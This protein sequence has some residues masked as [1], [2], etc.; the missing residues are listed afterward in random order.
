[1]RGMI[2]HLRYTVRLLLKSPGFTITAVLVLGLGI[3][4]NTA[5]FSLVYTVVLK[6]PPFPDPGRLVELTMPFQG[7]D[8]MPF[9]YPDY[10]DVRAEQ[11]SFESLAV[12][13]AEDMNLN[14]RGE[15]ER[16]TGAFVSAS[17]F[18]VTRM[19]FV[20]GRPFTEDD[21]KLGGPQVVVLNERFWRTHF[22]ADPA[23]IGRTMTISGRPLE[24]IGVAP[25][26]AFESFSV[27]LYIPMHLARR[28]DFQ[29]R[30][31]H[32]FQC[33]GRLKSAVQLADA[34]A[35]VAAIYRGIA[36]RY[37]NANIGYKTR[38]APLWSNVTT[39]YVPTLWVL[40]AAVVCLFLI[41]NANIVGLLFTRAL[42]RQKEIALR[43]ALGA[44]RSRVVSQLLSE[45][46]VL[47]MFG[48][49]V[50]LLSAVWGIQ[51]IKALSPKDE[52]ARFGEISFNLATLIFFAA[53]T[54]FSTVLL[55]LFPGWVLTRKSLNSA[56]NYER[57]VVF[58]TGRQRR[59]TQSALVVAQIS[60]ACV[61]CI[62]AGLLA[63]SF[64]ITQSI[65]LGFSSSQVLTAQ[66][67]LTDSKYGLG[68]EL[69]RELS[70]EQKAQIVA[71][72]DT[73]LQRIRNLPGIAA[74]ALN[75]I[76]PLMGA[77]RDPF[78]V[79]GLSDSESKP[80]CST[81]NVSSEY[82]TTL[83]I[84]L[85]L[86]R[87]FNADDRSHTERVVIIN[88]AFA[89]RYFPNQSPIGKQINFGGVIA[90]N[91]TVSFTIIGVVGSV[92]QEYPDEP[93]GP[94]FQAYFPYTQTP[95]NLEVLFLRST[96]EPG[97]LIPAIRKLVASIDPNVLVARSMTMDDLIA[98]GFKT[99]RLGM[100]VVGL[101]SGGALFLS[102]IGLYGILAYSVS[103][104]RRE[105]GIRI[106]VGAQALRILVLVMYGGFKIASIG[107]MIGIL[108][109]L[110]VARFMTSML[111]GI[112]GYD[113]TTL[114]GV[115][116]ILA[117]A[118]S[119]ACLF[120]AV[121][122]MRTDPIIVLKE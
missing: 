62:A 77:Q 59:F 75:K 91:K 12:Y 111:Y 97:T 105:L 82:F 38:V 15:T 72:Y 96:A 88:E 3:G 21:D 104:R 65:P 63:R 85:L 112:S 61:L 42:D 9:D 1:M 110:V 118:V 67:L 81:Q 28:V 10:E 102:A 50:G 24:V 76:P 22:N 94:M 18:K 39:F 58:T 14:S 19:S 108:C 54:V 101:F 89:R 119:M 56:L 40:G 41:A 52:F 5:I 79:P 114:V 103:Q 31:Q 66:I 106:A 115:A 116:L 74:A 98:E 34:Q 78:S 109:G 99:R 121:R 17:E 95:S 51:I 69:Q 32:E 120:P 7:V 27:D 87:D 73:L 16:V 100:L 80:V 122:A 43:V 93:P 25:T 8:W 44:S 84:P 30:D 68:R 64:Q 46:A 11:H 117:L 107:L 90:E 60:I 55:G 113:P 71:F 47:S 49:A 23:V 6:P 57:G 4:A 48:A 92:L 53:A 83:H 35:E 37:P 20:S 26:Q 2:S 29:S 86:G 36:K 13:T 45:S 70:S 33:V